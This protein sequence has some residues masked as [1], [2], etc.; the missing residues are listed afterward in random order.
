MVSYYARFLALLALI[1][2]ALGAYTRLSDSGLGCPDWPGCYGELIVPQGP[3]AVTK[4]ELSFQQTVEPMK[5]W[6]EMIHRYLAFSLGLG[7]LSLFFFE[8]YR[9]IRNR[10]CPWLLIT[11]TVVLMLQA[12]LGMWTVTLRLYPPIILLHLFGGL[13]LLSLLWWYSTPGKP[14]SDKN[15]TTIQ[16]PFSLLPWLWLGL[17]LLLVQIAL[18]GWTS[19]NYAAL[20]CPDFPYCQGKWLPTLTW[21]S[22]WPHLDMRLD[23]T[24]LVTIHM[25]HRLG[26]L[27]IGSYLLGLGILIWVRSEIPHALR[28]SL[29]LLIGL[30]I[31]ITLGILNIVLQL[32][33]VTAVAHNSVA[34][35]LVL[36]LLATIKQYRTNFSRSIQRLR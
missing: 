13:T 22:L 8:L 31:Q 27:T 15:Q 6:I 26:A 20:I 23:N 21:H 33:M 12:L 18:G 2:I 10:Y 25:A 19:A 7:I 3:D 32:P 9:G 29:L 24:A 35:L 14:C 30:F 28:Q 36:I 16:Q 34:M 4:A 17:G 5:A 1:V 11:L